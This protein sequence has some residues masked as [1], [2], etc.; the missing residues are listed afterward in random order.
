ML[1]SHIHLFNT[2]TMALARL[3]AY[4]HNTHTD[5][6]TTVQLEQHAVSYNN[7]LGNEW[8]AFQRTKEALAEGLKVTLKQVQ[9]WFV[10]RRSR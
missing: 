6:N 1:D 5:T 10:N 9:V 7:D 4:T 3:A 8:N 2:H